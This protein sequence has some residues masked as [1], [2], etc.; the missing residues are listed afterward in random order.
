MAIVSCPSKPRSIKKVLTHICSSII[1]SYSPHANA[2]SEPPT[3]FSQ[4]SVR[5]ALHVPSEGSW[6]KCTAEGIFRNRTDGSLAAGEPYSA[7]P[8]MTN[9]LSRVIEYTGNVI[10]GSGAMDMLIPTNGTLLVL[11]NVTWGGVQGFQ[12]RPAKPVSPARCKRGGGA[13]T[14]R[15]FQFYSPYPIESTPVASSMA[16]VIGT[17]GRE[18]GL[19]FY[20][21]D[22]GGHELPR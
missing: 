2:S 12:Q 5:T 6:G 8:A 20:E 19:T 11:Q 10:I 15:S 7:P 21:V 18:R 22:L 1:G 14:D 9:L 13:A 3:W 17:W 4:S 16:G